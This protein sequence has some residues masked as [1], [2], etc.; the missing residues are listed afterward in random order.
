MKYLAEEHHNYVDNKN[1]VY[2]K[3]K[4]MTVRIQKALTSTVKKYGGA[5]GEIRNCGLRIGDD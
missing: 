3:M 4:L 2:K 5:S 1:N